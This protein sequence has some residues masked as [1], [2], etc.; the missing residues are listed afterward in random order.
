MYKF[1]LLVL[2][3]FPLNFA[4]NA[5]SQAPLIVNVPGGCRHVLHGGSEAAAAAMNGKEDPEDGFE[6]RC[7][8]A[9]NIKNLAPNFRDYDKMKVTFQGF[10]AGGTRNAYGWV[11]K[12][13]ITTNNASFTCGAVYEDYPNLI[14]TFNDLSIDKIVLDG[15][16]CQDSDSCAEAQLFCDGGYHYVEGSYKQA[17][18]MLTLSNRRNGLGESRY[19]DGGTVC[20]SDTGPLQ[21]NNAA[22]ISNVVLTFTKSVR[23]RL[24]EQFGP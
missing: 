14:L 10:Q 9:V 7:D 19:C 8:F 3:V 23:R 24:P 17:T 4:S 20:G 11:D 13:L 16:A 1:L 2:I 15:C 22:C 6:L 12:S 21:N 5:H 18:G